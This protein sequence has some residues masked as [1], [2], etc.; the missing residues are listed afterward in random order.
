VSVKRNV[1]ANYLGQGWS[2]L[3]SLAFVPIYIGYLGMEAYGL[4]GVFAVMQAWLTLLDMGMTPTLTRELA[5]YEA[6]DHSTQSIADLMRT[7]EIVCVGVALL[8]VVALAGASGWIAHHWLQSGTLSSTTVQSAVLVA[9]AVI[10]LR[11]VEGLYRGAVLGL[12]RQ[13]WLNTVTASVAT[14]RSVGMI[15]VLAWVSPTI[16]AF[17]YWHALWAIIPAALCARKVHAA[18]PR[19]PQRPRFSV[20]ALADVRR[21]AGGIMATTAV[22]LLLTQVDK[23]VLSRMLSLE[24]FGYYALAS[25]V[26]GALLL[27]L[28]PITAAVYPRMVALVA[29]RDE[30]SLAALYHS[31]AQ[32]V[33]V[34][35]VPAALV[36]ALHAKGVLYAWSGDTTL[37]GRTAPL[38]SALVLGTMLNAL[39]HVPYCLQLAHGWT[40]LALRMNLVAVMVLVPA[41]LWLV[42]MHGAAAAAWIWAALNASYVLIGAP[43]MFRRLIPA[44]QRRWY[45]R[46]TALPALG[47]CVGLALVGGLVP[48]ALSSRLEWLAFLSVALLSALLCAAATIPA[49]RTRA[50]SSMRAW[51]SS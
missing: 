20:R 35:V 41:I 50:R 2:A 29:S 26:A 46:D 27:L 42:P 40:G 28:T 22:V 45:L 17:L 6:G 13:I 31:A 47:A 39:M 12:Q 51:M 11:F 18:L 48:A 1:V 38:L 7:L 25:A 32:L 33:T 10:A 44:A 30:R 9:G 36:L 24:S 34:V 49:V 21:F 37:A 8:I 16:E 3:M 23:V 15:A 43:L 14:A 19:A 5:R 4:I